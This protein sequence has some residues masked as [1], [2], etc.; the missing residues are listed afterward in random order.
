MEHWKYLG[1]YERLPPSSLS[2]YLPKPGFSLRNV[3]LRFQLT[4]HF[5][6]A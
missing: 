5:N 6:F 2:G 3:V 4:V 1:A